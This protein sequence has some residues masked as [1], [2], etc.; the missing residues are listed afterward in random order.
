MPFI[1][2]RRFVFINIFQ[3][4]LDNNFIS[5]TWNGSWVSES[6]YVYRFEVQITCTLELDNSGTGT[7]AS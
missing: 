6:N 1:A 7:T 3:E 2:L 5:E 4:I